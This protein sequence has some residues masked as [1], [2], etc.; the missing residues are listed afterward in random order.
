M[1]LPIS[2]WHFKTAL[3]SFFEQLFRSFWSMLL[4]YKKFSYFHQAC[5]RCINWL[6]TILHQQHDFYQ[7]QKAALS[8]VDLLSMSVY[9][10]LNV[11][12]HL[13][14]IQPCPVVTQYFFPVAD[15]WLTASVHQQLEWSVPLIES[16]L[17]YYM[18]NVFFISSNTWCIIR[19]ITFEDV[20][21][22]FCWWNIKMM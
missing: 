17:Q 11:L 20:L 9:N 7:Q 19:I 12:S 22:S 13:D 1:A 15:R 3:L 16:R 8:A 4:Q 21:S 18:A 2:L 10:D 6:G 14:T 5:K